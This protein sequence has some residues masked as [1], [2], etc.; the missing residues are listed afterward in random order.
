MYS[1][2]AVLNKSAVKEVRDNFFLTCNAGTLSN[3]EL[4]I[5]ILEP[6]MR[7]KSLSLTVDD[8]LQKGLPYLAS[9]SEYELST[10][11]GLNEKQSFHL[12]AV[13]EMARRIGR[14]V[15]SDKWVIRTPKDIQELIYDLK[16]YDKEHFVA[17]F[18]NTKNVVIGQ[19]TI[20]IGTLNSAL[21]HPRE[22]FKAAIR[23]GAA[24]IIACHN[25]P[26]GDPTPSPEDISLT[27]RIAEAGEIIGI[28]L[29]DHVII[30]DNNYVSLR[31]TGHYVPR[32]GN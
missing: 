15:I 7:D 1:N 11:F 32:G 23:R 5:M 9:L 30:A 3:K 25:H 12:L 31:E 6:L 21:V 14:M 4:L 20:S 24:S 26:S 16:F 13:F 2:L 10:L 17:V 18:L 29:L 28:E 19:E 27:R 22:V 8:I